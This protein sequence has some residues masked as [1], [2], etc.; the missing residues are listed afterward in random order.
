LSDHYTYAR[1]FKCALQ[2][3]PERYS[4]DYRG[5]DHG[6]RGQDFLDALVSACL[7]NGIEVIGLADHG[8]VQDVDR[9]RSALSA[10]GIVVFPGFEVATTEKVHWVCLFPEDTSTEQLNRYLGALGLTDPED[11]VRPSRLGG[12]ALLDVVHE[13]GGFCYAAHVTDDNGLLFRRANHL[14]KLPLL[15]AAQI[16]KGI[17]DLEQQFAQIAKDQD[18]AYKRERRLALI[19]AR[20]VAA[21]ADLARPGA[22]C[23]IKMTRPCFDAFVTAFKGPNSR[24]RL[25]HEMA[26]HHYS[27]IE[28]VEIDG[29]YLDG[30]RIRFSDHL[31]TAIGGRGTGKSTLLECL[32]YALDLDHKAQDAR[33]QGERIVKENLGAAGTVSVTLVSAASHG[34]RYQVKRRFGEPPRVIDA[35]GNVSELHPTE[36]LLPRLEFYGQ[37]EIFEL[38]R[39]DCALVGV[40]SRFM[41]DD[42]ESTRRLD[43]VRKAL[44]DNADRLARALAG[45]DDLEQDLARLPKLN[46]QV[47]QYKALGIEAKL[48]QVPLLEKERQLKPRF[49]E[50][51]ARVDEALETF[52]EELPDLTFLSD[53]VLDGLPHAEILR[54]GRTLLAGIN[55][56]VADAVKQLRGVLDSA[57]GDITALTKELEQALEAAE[58]RLEAEF[59]K[60]PDVGGKRGAEV[61]RT[62]QAL[63]RQIE[64]IQPKQARLQTARDL[65]ATLRQ[66]RRNLLNDWSELRSA[67]T[68]ALERVAKKLNRRLRGKVKIRVLAGGDR[69]A[70]KD[71]L[72]A[73][74]NISEKRVAWVDEAEELTIPALVEAARAGEDALR[75]TGWGLTAGGAQVLAKLDETKLMELEAIDLG[76]RVDLQ[77]NVSHEAE[78]YRSLQ[79]LST[80]QQC[81]AIL[82]LLLVYNQDPLIMDQPEDNLDNAFIAERIV[83]ELRSAKTER[84]F[85]FA[86]HNAN[87]PVFGDAEWIGVF[88]ASEDHGAVPSDRQGSIDVPV[89]RDEAAR[90]LE[91]GRTAFQQRQEI[92]GY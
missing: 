86:T 36:D 40:L 25:H 39:N 1:F 44:A 58:R 84:Q 60:L 52:A 17:E 66:E 73:F 51:W 46:E 77:L 35:D 10:A 65:T 6:L 55:T 2:V 67:R 33:K 75:A 20:D 11:G 23:W 32:R 79:Q 50:E 92:Y 4:A 43:E 80:G 54:R 38:A 78:Q 81:T 24:V 5:Q 82:N 34:A 47:A 31:N 90:I 8:S 63:L 29:G 28:A 49:A 41:P 91:G 56:G 68:A 74:P 26:P 64:Q 57:Q 89:I 27:R 3:N 22:S 53:A 61:G 15:R 7:D 69:T 88:S 59:A 72:C 71:W 14:W 18:P 87:I 83:S 21:P 13:C 37:N 85:I 48:K 30:L 16:P 9:I 12:E 45:Q 42:A 62:Y 76:D 70:L 19:N